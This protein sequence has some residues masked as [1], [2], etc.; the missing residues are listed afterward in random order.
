VKYEILG[1][2]NLS[3]AFIPVS[4]VISATSTS[5]SY[6]DPA[7]LTGQKFYLIEIVP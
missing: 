2:T 6:L 5:S 4:G 1:T 3:R 7:P